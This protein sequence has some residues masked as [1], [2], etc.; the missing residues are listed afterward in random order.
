MEAG[1]YKVLGNCF[2][3]VV[4][5]K[6]SGDEAAFSQHKV[7]YIITPQLKTDSSSPSPFTWPPTRFTVDLSAN[8]TDSAGKTVQGVD[9]AEFDEFKMEYSLSGRR[10]MEDALQKLQQL[11]SDAKELGK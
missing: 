2:A 1:F 10:A 5:L 4:R 6:L 9:H 8:I 3:D 7:G 11:L